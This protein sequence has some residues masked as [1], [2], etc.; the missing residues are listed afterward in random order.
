M[1]ARRWPGRQV[2]E[3]E[4]SETPRS[5]V[6]PAGFARR[7]LAR[8]PRPCAR[9]RVLK[10]REHEVHVHAPRL[11]AAKRLQD[12]PSE[13]GWRRD[14]AGLR[15]SCQW[16]RKSAARLRQ[17]ARI[18]PC[19]P[20]LTRLL[21]ASVSHSGLLSFPPTVASRRNT[22]AISRSPTQWLVRDGD[23]SDHAAHREKSANEA[24]RVGAIGVAC[25]RCRAA[26][27]FVWRHE[28]PDPAEREDVRDT[29]VRFS[30]HPRAAGKPTDV[31][32]GAHIRGR[33]TAA[34]QHVLAVARTRRAMK[35]AAVTRLDRRC[36]PDVHHP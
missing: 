15:L 14:R 18:A 1:V 3:R 4:D 28:C 12:S 20:N 34:I 23:V 35:T 10:K 36:R 31:H 5:Q 11:R 27:A 26:L 13:V 29:P 22:C 8:R 32:L 17:F 25:R 19:E 21:S 33:A 16:C 7:F 6:R 2:G 30:R 24:V 9:R